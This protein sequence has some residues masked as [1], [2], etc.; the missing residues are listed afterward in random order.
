MT[1]TP[2]RDAF[3]RVS[4]IS[5]SFAYF[6]VGTS[7]LCVIGLVPVISADL[8]VAAPDI[9]ILVTVFALTFAIVAPT[10]QVVLKRFNRAQILLLGLAL[11]AIGMGVG[12][13]APNYQ[14]LFA[15]RIIL[16]VGGALVSPMC[17]AI[18]SEMTVPELQGRAMALVFSGLAVSTVV[19]V[20][21]TAY[22]GTLFGWRL[23]MGLIAAL[24]LLSII[25]V[26]VKVRDS[27]VG[28]ATKFE[29]L[30]A[31]LGQRQT[32][33]AI[34][35]AFLQ[36]GAMFCTYALIAPYLISRYAMSTELVS[37][38]LMLYGACGLLGNVFVGRISD[39]IGPLKTL[40]LSMVG[41]IVGIL[42]VWGLGYTAFLALV[43]MC[44][45]SAFG[46]MFHAPQQHRIANMSREHRGLMMALN[47]SALYL[48]M[49]V[50]AWLSREVY[51]GLGYEFLPLASVGG[52]L[53]CIAALLMS[54]WPKPDKTSD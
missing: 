54:A 5:L 32:G 30:F 21:L 33:L 52:L 19:G 38:Y 24:A 12:A 45:W 20:P 9:A 31:L 14:M 15:S 17:S 51:V 36:M 4:L 11:I 35:T 2:S 10:G 46:M 18:G 29:H 27:Q 37:L 41:S 1:T 16:G 40:L 53:I 48:G 13:A 49:S 39:R 22:L 50:G 34:L 25:L 28:G 44:V 3:P 26:A 23:V 42:F 6:V 43:G 47:A 8:G 7:S